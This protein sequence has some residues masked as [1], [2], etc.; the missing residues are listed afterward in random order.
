MNQIFDLDLLCGMRFFQLSWHI[1]FSLWWPLKQSQFICW[2]SSQTEWL[3]MGCLVLFQLT[4]NSRFGWLGTCFSGEEPSYHTSSLLFS[5]T[6][7]RSFRDSFQS[8]SKRW[9][10]AS[11]QS[12]P[13]LRPGIPGAS[14]LP[15]LSETSALS[16]FTFQLTCKCH[17]TIYR[18]TVATT[19][20]LETSFVFSTPAGFAQHLPTHLSLLR[21]PSI[22]L[23]PPRY[24]PSL[25]MSQLS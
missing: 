8:S 17:H 16:H 5:P 23:A 6:F 19:G 25:N 1:S 14:F 18:F 21:S 12:Q 10:K 24:I 15:S 13:F 22:L 2:W 20:I 11:N 7:H 4:T 3:Q 9:K